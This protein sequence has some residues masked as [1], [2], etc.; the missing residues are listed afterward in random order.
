MLAMTTLGAP[1]PP[2][3]PERCD[4][5][6]DVRVVDAATGEHVPGA[7]VQ[8]GTKAAIETGEAGRYRIADVCPGQHTLAVERADYERASRSLR[9][10][11]ST[12]ADV[13]LEPREIEQIEDLVVEA[14]APSA[15]ELDAGTT[16]DGE[17]LDR[18]RGRNLADSIAKIPGVAVLRTGAGGM[19][20]PIIRGQDERRNLL[21]FDRVR[22]AG[23][24]WGLDHAPEIDAFAAGS[25]TVIKG[26]SAIRWGPDAIGGVVL[27][28]PVPLR[29]TPG[30]S[31][32]AHL[33][34][35]SNGKR[36]AVALAIDG[37]HRR[38]PG[39]VWRIEGNVTRGAATITPR[40]PLD[41][42]GTLQWNAGTTVG[43]LADAFDVTLSW[44]R[45][46]M[47]NGLCTCLR[48]DSPEEFTQ[49]SMQGRPVNADLY[50]R[51]Y[52]IER[53]QQRT[54]HDLAIAR[55]RVTLGDAGDL[56]ATYSLQNNARREYAIVRGGVNGPQYRFDLRTHGADV[57]F[58]RTPLPLGP[59]LDMIGTYGASMQ[60]QDNRFDANVTL[61]P[62]YIQTQGGVF[63]MERLQWKR[64]AL[65]AGARYDGMLRD[66][67]LTERDYEAQTASGRLHEARCSATDAG[68]GRCRFDFHTG[69]ASLGGILQPIPQAESFT[70]RLDLASAGRFP[71]IDEQF[72]NGTAPSLPILG[73]GD[74]R[75]GVER[76]WS[77][78]LGVAFANDWIATDGAAWASYIDDYIYF[79]PQPS[80]APG[81]L[82][83]TVHGTYPVFAFRPTGALFYGGEYGVRIAPP[84]WPV[85]FDGQLALVRARDVRTGGYLV[86]IPTD[87]YQLG[88]TYRWPELPRLTDG[89]VGVSVSYV[90]RQ[91][92]FDI[93]ADFVAPPP[94]YVQLG[95]QAGVAVPLGQQTLRFALV[96]T[97]LTNTRYRDYTSLL[98]YFADEPGWELLVRISF[99]FEAAGRKGRNKGLKT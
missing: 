55:T 88:V 79:A 33:V 14:P 60:H 39:L 19:G 26:T 84:K 62:D 64:F 54:V 30:V 72:L 58:E 82:N 34:G 48:N 51:E 20:K 90:D 71:M 86:F 43:Y 6:V 7:R 75:L 78:A 63:A 98:R 40:Y 11:G 69:S 32:R 35:V 36:G 89:F 56:T 44:R 17:A 27:V 81:G 15:S 65:E 96:G 24:K 41:N 18:T 38:A 23:Q 12:R 87:R 85:E 53:P 28:D 16:L 22:H 76:T 2:G 45:N 50:S 92:R 73:V 42:T 91:R 57:V 29:T 93:D 10:V 74:A 99:D 80:D 59:R 1:I 95:A 4:L 49:S 5:A 47:T 94:G 70:I 46:T 13:A 25:I 67:V 68:G 52:R 21:L 77:S 97:N 37:A 8:L 66:A 31:G 9:V 3:P 83:D 61:V